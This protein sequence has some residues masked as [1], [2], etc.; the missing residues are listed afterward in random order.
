MIKRRRVAAPR[1]GRLFPE[2][3]ENPWGY[4]LLSDA[5]DGAPPLAVGAP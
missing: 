2:L 1:S 5:E 4:R 3:S